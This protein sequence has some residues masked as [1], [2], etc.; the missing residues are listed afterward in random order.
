MAATDIEPL[1]GPSGTTPNGLPYPVPNDTVDVPRDILALATSLDTR[2]PRA[3]A[4]ATVLDVGLVGQIRA[5]RQLALADF[6][7]LGLAAPVGLW[8]LANVNDASGNA[9]NLTNKG[10]VP[11]GVGINGIATTAAVF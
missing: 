5:G 7:A 9:R 11:F 2:V 3:L 10:T 6:T 4:R 1:A 8:N